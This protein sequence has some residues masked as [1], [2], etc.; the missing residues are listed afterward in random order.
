MT[1]A[2]RKSGFGNV[3]KKAQRYRNVLK[4]SEQVLDELAD[5][6]QHE[7]EQAHSGV[8]GTDVVLG[9]D[10]YRFQPIY[11][12]IKVDIEKT[13]NKR[14]VVATGEKFLFYEFGSGIVKNSPRNWTNILNIPVPD[15]IV[16]IGQ[17][18][19]GQGAKDSWIY[20]DDK[21]VVMTSGYA[22]RHGF[23]NAINKVVAEV[24]GVIE[25]NKK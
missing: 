5:M 7:I 12:D 6:A 25:E 11:S 2:F 4:N 15:E 9:D 10:G 22:A 23:A 14:S 21:G 16:P 13:D 18:G 17:Y 20:R 1:K 3:K 8:M 24:K 19:Y